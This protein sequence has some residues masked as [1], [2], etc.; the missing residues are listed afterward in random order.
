MLGPATLQHKGA[1]EIAARNG[2]RTVG[3]VH[4]NTTYASAVAQGVRTHAEA[5]G[6]EVVFDRSYPLGGADHEAL[7]SG[8]REAGAEMLAGGLYFPDAVAFT[9]AVEATG[10]TPMLIALRVGA[11]DPLFLQ[12]V[13]DLARCVVG[14]APWVPRMRTSG[15]IS[16]GPTFVQRY[17]AEH[18]RPPNYAVAAG[19]GT[20]ELVAEAISV[21][22]TGR[23]KVD[24]VAMRDHLFAF[25]GGTVLG[26]FDVN[27][28]G[29]EEAGAQLALGGVQLQWQDDGAGGL[30]QRTIHPP[31]SAEAEPCFLRASIAG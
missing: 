17:E 27:P 26:P 3:I 14:S 22:M 15:F 10:Y 31:E 12:E 9:R 19:F 23:G 20:V 7:M 21:A 1:V 18:D 8:A 11:E 25:S 16:D 30:V 6:L 24:R 4:E 13:G 5:N 29:H 28:P 2:I